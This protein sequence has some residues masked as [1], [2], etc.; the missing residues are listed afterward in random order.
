METDYAYDK[1]RKIMAIFYDLG[2]CNN[3]ET[4]SCAATA[5]DMRLQDANEIIQAA[6]RNICC[7]DI[8]RGYSAD[9]EKAEDCRE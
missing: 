3:A 4:I 9:D 1:L 5:M 6:L 8:Y 7:T 2:G